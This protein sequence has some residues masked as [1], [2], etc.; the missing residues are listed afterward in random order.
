MNPPKKTT[1]SKR[2]VPKTAAPPPLKESAASA[3]EH[4]LATLD[5]EACTQL[6]A[7]VMEQVEAPLFAAVLRHTEDNQ[8]Q[9]AAM[10]GLNRGTLRKKL[11]EYGLLAEAEPQTRRRSA[12]KAGRDSHSGASTRT[13]RGRTSAANKRK[14]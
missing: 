13:Q 14:R 11:R 10:L 12:K 3:I 6:H 7:M 1:P 9:A 8:S 4:Y 2:R 5:G